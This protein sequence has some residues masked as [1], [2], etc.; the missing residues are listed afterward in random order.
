M[1]CF[2]LKPPLTQHPLFCSNNYLHNNISKHFISPSQKSS[3]SSSQ[4]PFLGSN[5]S[6]LLLVPSLS[7]K[8]LDSKTSEV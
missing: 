3:Q 4:Q 1:I 6:I 5:W 7:F 8:V 2:L